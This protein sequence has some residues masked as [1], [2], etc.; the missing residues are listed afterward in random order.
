MA[1]HVT[2]QLGQADLLGSDRQ[3]FLDV[4]V[5]YDDRL[6]VAVIRPDDGCPRRNP[7][8][9]SIFVPDVV[10]QTVVARIVWP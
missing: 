1:H 2:R 8:S 3:R 9:V 5:G 10:H 7:S 6:G 4:D